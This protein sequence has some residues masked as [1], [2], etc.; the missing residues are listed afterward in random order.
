MYEG[1]QLLRLNERVGAPSGG[2]VCCS[3]LSCL[4]TTT[5]NTQRCI[6]DT[7]VG[8]DS[9]DAS[10]DELSHINAVPSSSNNDDG[11]EERYSYCSDHVRDPR[12]RHLLATLCNSL[13]DRWHFP[14]INDARRNGAFKRAI[15]NTVKECKEYNAN[16]K[17]TTSG[18]SVPEEESDD[19]LW[20]VRV[21]DIGCGTALLR[22]VLRRR[23]RRGGEGE[24][25]RCIVRLIILIQSMV[26]KVAQLGE[27]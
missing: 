18:C 26:G 27:Y 5:H 21:L 19:S 16:R 22:F 2:G 4:A 23:R 12:Y 7:I 6:N 11:L 3:V 20:R 17:K 8:V 13:V 15:E 14:M 24:L 10:S 9:K 25:G 1:W